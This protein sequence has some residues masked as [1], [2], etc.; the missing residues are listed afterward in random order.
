MRNIL[1]IAFKL[2]GGY[3]GLTGITW[4]QGVGKTSF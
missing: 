4:F 1:G 3:G 2:I